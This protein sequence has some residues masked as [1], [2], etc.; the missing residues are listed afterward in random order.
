MI[1]LVHKDTLKIKAT[2]TGQANKDDLKNRNLIAVESEYKL[3]PLKVKAIRIAGKV[4][5]LP[6]REV[7]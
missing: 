2:I 3:S 4:K 5:I 1:Y 6:K 7:N